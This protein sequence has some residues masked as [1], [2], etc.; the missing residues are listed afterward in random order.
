[1]QT[2]KNLPKDKQ[3]GGGVMGRMAGKISDAFNP[4]DED[5]YWKK[6]HS[7][8]WFGKGR[9]YDDYQ[10]AYRTGYEGYQKYGQAGKTFEDSETDLQREYERNRGTSKLGWNECRDAA[11]AAWHKVHG[12]WERLIDY[13]VHDQSDE[14]IGTVHNLWADEGGQPSF[15]GVKTGWFSGKNHVVPAH[16]AMM[17]DSKKIIRLPYD[18]Q[19][20]KDAPSFD[21]DQDLTDADENRIYSYYGTA[22]PRMQDWETRQPAAGQQA[23][24]PQREMAAQRETGMP[25]EQAS[26]QLSEEQLKVGK[27]E[28]EA[29]GVRLRKVVRYETVNQP[30][31][32][33]REEVVIE[34]VPTSGAQR[35]KASFEGQDVFIP[36]RREEAVVEKEARVREEVR[37]H[38][39]ASTE[40]QS[41]SEKV[42]KEDVEIEKE[43]E[44][45]FATD[46]GKARAGT[47]RY[48]PKERSKR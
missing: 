41:I 15:I 4:A 11:R 17:N 26:M 40:Q 35:G 38:K 37:A 1:M 30:V 45:R 8:Q 29:G 19:K 23:A 7:N 48:E 44:A 36:L 28:V 18:E 24:T 13:D 42:R 22:R 43:G 20:I 32:L 31:E 25:R 39:E 47:P 33:R 3:T 16:R 34:R 14:K 21:A 46:T 5:A 9:N 2:E 27:R 6:H 10:G 12:R